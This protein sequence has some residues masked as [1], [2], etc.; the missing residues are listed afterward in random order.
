M[1][2]SLVRWCFVLC[3]EF[4]EKLEY[5]PLRVN[6]AIEEHQISVCVRKRPMN[7]KEVGRK[8]VDVTT[9]PN[10]DHV[11]VHQPQTKVDL[12]KVLDNQTFRFDYAFDE[13]VSNDM[14]YRYTAPSPK[15]YSRLCTAPF[16]SAAADRRCIIIW[17]IS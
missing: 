4:R 17:P 12:T 9:V 14:V 15:P 5:Y 1:S 16:C 10:R 11:V 6:D 8:E 13:H 2:Q 3:R 7:K